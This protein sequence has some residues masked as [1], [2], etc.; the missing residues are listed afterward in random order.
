M[1]YTQYAEMRVSGDCTRVLVPLYL[2][3]YFLV[4]QLICILPPPPLF[5][6]MHHLMIM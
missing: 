6:Y 2:Y 3:Q 1:L 5:S 4:F